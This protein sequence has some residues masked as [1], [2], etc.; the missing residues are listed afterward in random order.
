MKK[1]INLFAA[2]ASIAFLNEL[3]AQ[4]NYLTIFDTALRGDWQ[5]QN[6]EGYP[7][8]TDFAASAPGRPGAKAIEVNFTNYWD[9]FGLA[10]MKP[11]WDIQWNYLNEV[12]T[13]EFDIYF[14]TNSTSPDHLNFILDDNGLSDA[15]AISS[16]IPNWASLTDSQRYGHWFHATVDLSA[17]HPKIARFFR[18]I[19]FNSGEFKPHFFLA[20]IQLGWVNRTNPPLITLNSATLN[21]TYDQLTLVYHTDEYTV[22]QVDYGVGNFGNTIVGDANNW[23]TDF[24]F[25]LTNL[26][27]GTTVQYRI[28]ARDHRTDTNAAPNISYYTNT[29]A[30]PLK[31]TQPPAI[32][33]FTA[34]NVLGNRATLLWNTERPCTAQLT[35][36]KTGGPDLNRSFPNLAVNQ[37][38]V[39]DLIEAMTLYAVT[40]I[41]TDAFG[42]TNLQSTTFTS[43]TNSAPD[44]VITVNPSQ[45]HKIS[46]YIY[47][48]NDRF[49][50]NDAPRNLPFDRSGGNRWTAYN[51]ENNASNAGNDW[52]FE[53]DDYLGGGETP[54]EAAR[55]RV[56]TDHANGVA[57]LITIPLQGYV[58]ADKN[59]SVDISDPNHLAAR[60]KQVAFKKGSAFAYPPNTNDDYVY[61]DEFLWA[62]RNQFT[63]DIYGDT[64][65]PVFVSLDNEPDLWPSTHEEIQGSAMTPVDTFI[66]NSKSM[67]CAIKDLAPGA[68]TFGP[69]NFGF[70]GMSYW[71]GA[72]A[73]FTADNWFVDKYLTE[74]KKAEQSEGRRLL[75]VY[76]FH[77]YPEAVSA[78]GTRI[79]KLVQPNL[80][81]DAIQTI[82]QNPRSLWDTNFTEKSWIA[83][84]FGG[85]IFI[86]KRMQD[87][88]A[89]DYPGTGLAITEYQFGGENN[90]AGAVAEA[91]YL[92]IFGSLDLFAASYW[93]QWTNMPFIAAGFDMYRDYD[94]KLGTF[95]DI[96]IAASSSSVSNVTAYVSADSQHPSRHVIVAINRSWNAQ[97]VAF[98][99][100]NISGLAKI[101]RV[102]DQ[103]STP[104]FVGSVPADLSS[105]VVTLPALSVSTIE[106]TAAS[107]NYAAWLAN[108]FTASEQTNSVI[109]GMNAD[110]EHIGMPNL[111]RYAF[112]LPGRGAVAQTATPEIVNFGNQ[113]FPAI[114]FN[115]QS[116]ASDLTY[117]IESSTDLLQWTNISTL[118][119][120]SPTTIT[121]QDATPLN[122][123][124]TRFL[125]VRVQYLPQ[126]QL[127]R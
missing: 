95:G 59:G 24:A 55:S 21:P 60:F 115:R 22:G 117:L 90:I 38:G 97:D 102:Q 100:I 33:S 23:N 86:L 68:K 49:F 43:G 11:G 116:S 120:G 6:W 16:L 28:A 109:S 27:F 101:Y 105:W 58:T 119:A 107:N 85:P 29:F 62:L 91:D 126:A 67:C 61:D 84:Y 8:P 110:P 39:L 35:Y 36:H 9:G 57:S 10:D 13:V 74:M 25:T 3:P 94:G 7:L 1:L 122:S 37:A 93:R 5:S 127:T 77:W 104:A 112:N 31:P 76:D 4:T 15:P 51:W 12:R 72:Y 34:T 92:G 75:D 44:V 45:T 46:P 118:S 82:V 99:G 53:S 52:Y 123:Q 69:V 71:Q 40:V 66:T 113:K 14:A 96:S 78:N 50:L 47:G 111:L 87:K 88:I 63:N 42:Y 54:G 26:S 98:F 20:N 73:D 17:I 30:V 81:A 18:F 114:Q 19:L 65:L 64:N 121:V 48:I 83:D 124:P 106:I 32:T 70:S 89:A 108:N 56:A 41:V 80:S 125:R 79:G 2:M 103:Q